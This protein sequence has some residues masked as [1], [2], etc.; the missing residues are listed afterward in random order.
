[1]YIF[2]QSSLVKQMSFFHETENI[3]VTW[4]LASAEHRKEKCTSCKLHEYKVKQKA[5]FKSQ[6]THNNHTFAHINAHKCVL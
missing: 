6:A 2:Q 4:R 1:M 5:Y 3:K